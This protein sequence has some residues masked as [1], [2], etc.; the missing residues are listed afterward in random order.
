MKSLLLGT[1]IAAGLGGCIIESDHHHQGDD[2]GGAALL[3]AH[4]ELKNIDTQALTTCPAGF[5][6]GNIITQLVDSAGHHVGPPQNDLFDCEDHVDSIALDPGVYEVSVAIENRDAD[7]NLIASYQT[8][9]ADTIDLTVQD[10]TYDTQI[11]NDGGRAT[12]AWNL[13]GAMTQTSLPCSALGNGDISSISTDMAD[14]THV[15]DHTFV[16]E[17]GSVPVAGPAALQGD[18]EL[19]AGSWTLQ[20][21]AAQ[22][23]A[24]LSDVISKT[25][26]MG[27]PD[28]LQDLGVVTLHLTGK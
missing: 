8:S 15:F 1:L 9:L 18:L 2:G 16:C 14:A 3:T 11:L 17:D 7:A 26:T 21:N 5:N 28:D 10:G 22:D 20:I 27:Q 12:F 23:G 19:T 24:S 6:T 25:V 13:I 4:W